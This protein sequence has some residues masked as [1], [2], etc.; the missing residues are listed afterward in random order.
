[1]DLIELSGLRNIPA[2][3]KFEAE[4]YT[5]PMQRRASFFPIFIIFLL[6]SGIIFFFARSG[7]F[8]GLT[9]FFEQ[10]TVPLQRFVF[11]TIHSEGELSSEEKLREENRNLLTQLAKQKELERENRALHDQFEATNPVP[12]EL[13]PVK[14]IGRNNDQ[15]IIDK[16]SK[17]NI[18]PGNI[19]VYKD[20]LVGKV[21]KV[22]THL[23]VVHLATH[24]TISFTAEAIKTETLGVISGRGGTVF[25][26]GN[27]V[28]SEKLEKD[29]LVRTKG[30]VDEKGLGFPPDLIVGKIIA[31]N[32]QP[33]ALFQSAEVRSLVDF[34]KLS[35][36]FVLLQK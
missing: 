21:V 10:A 23:S 5:N 28:L 7:A 30:D 33:S 11:S 27:I 4:C 1:M 32:K 17:E 9:G 31:V 14:I 29:D 19:V 3:C 13:L 22:S 24:P 18:I 2:V 20:N 8:A 26:F 12:Q 25:I 35:T 6:L 34:S 36:V 15:L 16:G